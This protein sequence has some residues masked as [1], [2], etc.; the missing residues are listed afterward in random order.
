MSMLELSVIYF[1]KWAKSYHFTFI[2]LIFNSQLCY[3]Y[4]C[5][6]RKIY[7]FYFIQ[8]LPISTIKLQFLSYFYLVLQKLFKCCLQLLLTN[9][10]IL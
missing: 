6:Q 2:E 1:E 3:I 9:I 5:Q 7:H 8:K 10:E 4:V